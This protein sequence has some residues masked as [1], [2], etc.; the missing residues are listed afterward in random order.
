MTTP[1][2]IHARIDQCILELQKLKNEID[3]AALQADLAQENEVFERTP[4]YLAQRFCSLYRGDVQAQRNTY[5]A[6]ETLK[7]W[8]RVGVM[9]V[10][11]FLTE[12]ENEHR[13]RTEPLFRLKDRV[14]G[15]GRSVKGCKDKLAEYFDENGNPRQ[16]T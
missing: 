16:R 4:A 14:T 6:A 13:D 7:E 1:Q 3:S 11:Q 9:T 12:L 15:N 8:F 2:R 5:T 10:D